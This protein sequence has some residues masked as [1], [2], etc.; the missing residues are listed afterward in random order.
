MKLEM[1]E[2]NDDIRI[3]EPYCI[4]ECHLI[5]KINQKLN[6]LTSD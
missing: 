6:A 3:V 5:Q 2:E 1:Y 4:D